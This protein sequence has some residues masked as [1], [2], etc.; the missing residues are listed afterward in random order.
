VLAAQKGMLTAT[1]NLSSY[2]RDEFEGF[3]ATQRQ[4][5]PAAGF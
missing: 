4:K 2:T 5:R 3:V 1:H